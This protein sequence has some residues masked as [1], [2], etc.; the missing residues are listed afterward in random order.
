MKKHEEL[1][2]KFGELMGFRPEQV[3]ACASGT[4]ALHLALEAFRLPPLS[5]VAVPDLTMVACPRA[6]V[7]AG[8]TPHFAGPREDLNVGPA[9]VA[10][11][12][13][14]GGVRAIMAVHVYGRRC[15]MDALAAVARDRDLLLIE[16][17]AELH[18]VL[19]H[20]ATDA[21]CWSF[22]RNKVIAGEEGGAVAFRDPE[23]ATL[24]RS[25]RCLGF[26]KA[27][28]F[29]HLPRGHNYRMSEAHASLVL[30]SLEKLE[31]NW[32]LRR[33]REMAL[34]IACP[35]EWRMPPR[36]SPWVYDLRI[37]D[38]TTW[39]QTELVRRLNKAGIAAR[40]CFKPMTLQPEWRDTGQLPN[41]LALR[42][43]QE[44]V[45][46]PLDG[47]LDGRDAEAFDLLRG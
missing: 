7:L 45:Y 27:H 43:S 19:P 23:A 40:Y 5:K 3:V 38:L 6:V 18:G 34:E 41:A 1:E 17:M 35:A 21:A 8:L 9:D 15:D 29:V 22:Y 14:W 44:V 4:A 30:D 26:T 13:T 25:L 31:E 36:L 42:L 28:D 37:R 39:R 46:L 16:D 47:S 32:A 20:P 12:A 11:R 33:R 10:D 24:A 2:A